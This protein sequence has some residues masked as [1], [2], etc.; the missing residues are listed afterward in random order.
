MRQRGA[1]PTVV[2]R[3]KLPTISRRLPILNGPEFVACESSARRV[4]FQAA[5]P[6]SGAPGRPRICRL[7]A[8][9]ASVA[10]AVRDISSRDRRVPGCRSGL[11]RQP[12]SRDYLPAF[13]ATLIV[14]SCRPVSMCKRSASIRADDGAVAHIRCHESGTGAQDSGSLA[15]RQ[16][17]A[18]KPHAYPQIVA[19]AELG[20][21]L[22]ASPHV[23]SCKRLSGAWVR[24]FWSDPGGGAS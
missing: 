23:S 19:R 13:G 14:S 5:R 3:P 4:A 16:S 6:G 20:E 7:E 11:P 15:N 21:T 17:R 1:S 9:P 18:S 2:V 24:L 8:R 12:R 22:R 10:T